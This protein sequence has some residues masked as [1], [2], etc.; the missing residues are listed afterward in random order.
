MRTQ[1]DWLQ[2]DI[3]SLRDHFNPMSP[4]GHANTV[5]VSRQMEA[6]ALERYQLALRKLAEATEL[7]VCPESLDG[8]ILE[9][10][11]LPK[12]KTRVNVSPV[13]FRFD[14]KVWEDQSDLAKELRAFIGLPETLP[15]AK[16]ECLVHF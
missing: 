9:E 13:H 16:P 8:L 15:G 5:W 12:L 1:A 10:D 2:E 4:I 14:S 7:G 11:I 6:D 3:D